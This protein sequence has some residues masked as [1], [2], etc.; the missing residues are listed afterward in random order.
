M[1]DGIRTPAVSVDAVDWLRMIPIGDV[2]FIFGACSRL[3][4]EHQR[5][6]EADLFADF[7]RRAAN[8]PDASRPA[9]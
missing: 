6:S 1:T 2:A 8:D 5:I 7:A 3:I 9:T 4:S